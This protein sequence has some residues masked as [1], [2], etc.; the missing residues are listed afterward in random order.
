M[1]IAVRIASSGTSLRLCS[2]SSCT[3]VVLAF[4]RA[5][6]GGGRSRLSGSVLI[7]LCS[8]RIAET[9]STRAWWIFV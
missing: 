6:H 8:S 3:L 2:T 4:L 1:P 7:T 9:P 5:A